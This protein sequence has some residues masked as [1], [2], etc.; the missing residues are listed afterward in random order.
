MTRSFDHEVAV[1][2]AGP[3]GIGTGVALE[4]LDLEY[5]VLERDCIGASFRQWP[6]EMRLLTP[7]FP[8]TAFGTRDLNAITPDTSPALAL[9]CEHPTGEQYA[10][11]LEAI[12]EFHELSVETGI[13]VTSAVSL[14]GDT[15]GGFRLETDDDSITARFVVW[16]AGEYQYPTTA[17]V[18][19]AQHGVHVAGV[20]SWESYATAHDLEADVDLESDV[21]PVET[22]AAG[23]GTG[24]ATPQAAA[25]GAGTMAPVQDDVIVIGGA[26]SGVDAALSLAEADC[27]VTVLDD[28][29]TWQFRSPDPSEVLSPR[30]NERLEAALDEEQPIALVAGARAERIERLADEDSTEIDDGGLEYAVVTTDGARFC[31]RAP[32]VLATGFEGS[33]SLVEELFTL[34]DG[35]P[36]LTDRDESTA[37]PGLFLAG[38]QVAHNGQEFCFIY[39]YR[40]RFAVVAETIGERLGVDTDALEEYRENNMFLEDL[41]CC[42]PEYCDW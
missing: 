31:S 10:D 13:D 2:G 19:G 32:P 40:Q 9:D 36:E 3:A 15:D 42:E 25:D 41:E 14:D 1:I 7:S 34:E 37:T 33:V 5:T 23:D 18:A 39:K 20:D 11:Y 6:A 12:A 27:S 4:R 28:A 29:G 30:T 8:A 22:L 17:A 24:D 21:A 16:A 26:E 38:P 35:V